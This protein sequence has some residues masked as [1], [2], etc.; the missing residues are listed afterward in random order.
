[1]TRLRA[2]LALAAVALAACAA[3]PPKT[4]ARPATSSAPTPPPSASLAAP[5]RDAGAAVAEV[6]DAGGVVDAGPRAPRVADVAPVL[7]PEAS[8]IGER[9]PESLPEEARVRC[10]YDARYAPDPRAAS[11]AHGLL[12]RHGIVAGVERAH[13]MDGGYRGT[14]RITPAVPHGD[15]RKHLAWLE[16]SFADF[17]R[18]FGDLARAPGDAGPPA[19]IPYRYRPITLRFMRSDK[20]EGARCTPARTP[21]AYA[22]D[23]TIAYHL[24]GSLNTSEDAVRETMFHEIFHLNDQA[25]DDWSIRALGPIFDRIVAKCGTRAACLAPYAPNDTMVRGGTYYAFQ[26]GNGVR[27]YA[28]ELAVRYYKE[29]RAALRGERQP[30]PRFK[31]GNAENKAAWDAFVAELFGGVD[32]APPCP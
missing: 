7:F 26:P 18:F 4:D 5:E 30:R 29:Q 12:A 1:M 2:A 17:E 15:A 9:C 16:A 3:P 28:A 25:R 8:A 23:W 19:T 14:L 20:C 31:C 32:R 24:D 11:I 21:S 22:W 6:V 13:M 27:E 10:F